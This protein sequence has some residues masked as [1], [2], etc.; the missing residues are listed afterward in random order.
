MLCQP[1]RGQSVLVNSIL[2]DKNLIINIIEYIQKPPHN[3]YRVQKGIQILLCILGLLGDD[4]PDL[5]MVITLFMTTIPYFT[6]LLCNFSSSSSSPASLSSYR[7]PFGFDRLYILEFFVGL[8]YTS[9]PIVVQVFAAN[10]VFSVVLAIFLR[11]PWNNIVHHQ[12]TLLFS[13]LLCSSDALLIK[14]VCF[15]LF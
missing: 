8:L 10:S 13:G 14:S 5:P 9:F 15:F 11:Y 4:Q 3:S 7:A 1:W 6:K 12:I 2:N